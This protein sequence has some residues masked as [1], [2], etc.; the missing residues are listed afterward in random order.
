MK[1]L[2][3]CFHKKFRKLPDAKRSYNRHFNKKS[4]GIS[5]FDWARDNRFEATWLKLLIT[6]PLASVR[7]VFKDF[8]K[9]K[10]TFRA[11]HRER[12]ELSVSGPCKNWYRCNSNGKEV[13]FVCSPVAFQLIISLK[14]ALYGNDFLNF[15]SQCYFRERLNLKPTWQSYFE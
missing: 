5:S 11:A 2:P 10:F 6:L 15:S 14:G 4:R 12:N 1:L 3:M 7:N 9:V 13:R 8:D